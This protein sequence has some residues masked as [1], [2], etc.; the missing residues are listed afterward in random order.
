M[1]TQLS[2]LQREADRICEQ[3][4]RLELIPVQDA[5]KLLKQS[6]RWVRAN[7]P[8]IV[9]SPRSQRVRSVDVEA[10]LERRTVWPQLNGRKAA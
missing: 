1:T 7:L 6:P 3:L 10:F 5:A 9:T 2:K 8:L 4:R